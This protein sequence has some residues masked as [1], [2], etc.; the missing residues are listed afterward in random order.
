M[1]EGDVVWKAARRLHEALAG[2]TLTR[3]DFRVP[4]YATADLAGRGVVDTVSYGKHLLT[5]VEGG[6]TVHTH[7]RMDG[8]WSVQRPGPAPRDHRVRLVLAN[9]GA[10][11]V[12]YSLGVVELLPT[13]REDGVV[14][15]LGPD[16]LG[17]GWGADTA[18]EAVRRLAEQPDRAIGEAL[19]DQTR[20]AGIGNIYKAEILFLRGTDPW[21]A[22]RDVPDLPGMVDLAHRLM[23][24][25]R[26]RTGHVTTGDVRPGRRWWAY[27]RGGKP[28]RRC[29]TR[30]RQGEQASGVGE[31]VVYWCPRCQPRR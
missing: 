7:L 21:T 26:A 27:G 14:G 5:R 13:D 23:F 3:T 29:G 1:P 17:D 25:N 20:L 19:L 2:R 6:V 18:A 22:V 11:A 28:C 16:L 30:I 10:Q 4:R 24:A 9:A 15:H 8:R 31:R 12:G